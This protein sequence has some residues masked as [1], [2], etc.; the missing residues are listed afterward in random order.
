MGHLHM[1]PKGIRPT[2]GEKTV[3]INELMDSIMKPDII[4]E[5]QPVPLNQHHQVDVNVF[6][7]AE[8]NGMISTDL[9]FCFARTQEV[10]TEQL[11]RS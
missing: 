3:E 6:R 7:F 9:Q 1:I 2:P 8:L 5:Q 4:M 11:Y 10:L